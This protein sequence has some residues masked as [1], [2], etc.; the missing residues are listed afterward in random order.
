MIYAA[1]VELPEFLVLKSTIADYKTYQ[2]RYRKD[3]IPEWRENGEID[4]CD[5]SYGFK[6]QYEFYLDALKYDGFKSAKKVT[7]PTLIV[8]G[9]QD[10]LGTYDNVVKLSRVLP[11]AELVTIEGGDHGCKKDPE[12]KEQ[13]VRTISEFMVAFD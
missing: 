9:D 2:E 5:G 6:L 3:I 8:N 1:E 4:F 7:C 11:D 12:H 10:Q 13:M